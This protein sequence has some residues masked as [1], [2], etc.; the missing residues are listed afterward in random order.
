VGRGQRK[1]CECLAG[2]HRAVNS[3][4]F[5][6][7]GKYI[8]TAGLDGYARIWEDWR[9]PTPRLMATVGDAKEIWTAAFSPNGDYLLTGRG[10]G[11]IL[12]WEWKKNPAELRAELNF[13]GAG[14]APTPSPS[15]IPVAAAGA[16]SVVA[17]AVPAASPAATPSRAVQIF[18]AA[19]SP[20]G[21]FIIIA[22]NQT[23]R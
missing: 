17:S 13:A 9:T 23:C 6:R 15:P 12:V 3:A 19:F 8:V 14:A 10:S 4:S 16:K 1:K 5:S 7:D 2:A 18:K 21:E 22:A 11:K 20:D